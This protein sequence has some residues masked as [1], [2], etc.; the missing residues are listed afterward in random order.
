M[1]EFIDEQAL[2]IFG[3]DLFGRVVALNENALH[4]TAIAEDRLEDEFEEQGLEPLVGVVLDFHLFSGPEIGLAAGINP[5]QRI[6]ITLRNHLRQCL[7]DGL[8]DEVAS[9]D[10]VAIGGVRHDEAMVAGP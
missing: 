6:D 3:M 4:F 9:A 1:I 5:V 2:V 7:A 10:K 8:T